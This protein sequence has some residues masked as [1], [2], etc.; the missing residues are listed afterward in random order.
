M[1]S[2]H[3]SGLEMS[4]FTRHG[5]GSWED[6]LVSRWT[7]SRANAVDDALPEYA[8][9]Q[10]RFCLHEG[11]LRESRVGQTLA[12][13]RH[14]ASGCGRKP[15]HGSALD[16]VGNF[17]DVFEPS[18]L[19]VLK[20]AFG[21][22]TDIAARNEHRPVPVV[23]DHDGNFFDAAVQMWAALPLWRKPV[24]SAVLRELL[25][26][27][28]S[29]GL[30]VILGMI[31]SSAQHCNAGK[32]DV[33]MHM[34]Q[35]VQPWHPSA[36]STSPQ[37]NEE[38]SSYFPSS[39]SSRGAA[40]R[41][42]LHEAALAFVDDWK[43]K[44]FVSTFLEPTKMYY[45]ACK[46]HGLEENVGVHGASVYLAV[47]MSTLG[48]WCP[49]LPFLLDA[50]ISAVSFLDALD[51]S[52]IRALWQPEHLG[53]PF[54]S[55]VECREPR[56][57]RLI[58]N[59]QSNFLF[60]GRQTWQIANNAVDPNAEPE[61]RQKLQPYLEQFAEYFSAEILVPKLT[62][63]LLSQDE[64]LQALEV[65]CD[66]MR[67]AKCDDCSAFGRVDEI[68]DVRHWLWNC[69]VFPAELRL[70]RAIAL[71]R[72]AGLLR[73]DLPLTDALDHGPDAIL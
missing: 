2:P 5:C 12:N 19:L 54:S 60:N 47:L 27:E 62:Q 41:A 32:V 46:E 17:Y 43:E 58:S 37:P 16:V 49:R 39:S 34:L 63:H 52:Q 65:M 13:L 36:S 73:R 10:R 15:F 68:G 6:Y 31:K 30:Q 24:M 64:G 22:R 29:A 35:R 1:S 7:S 20:K 66:E 11:L 44:A 28:D 8:A 72:H 70:G 18:L 9:A 59:H 51:A 21:L 26:L 50:P 38:P 40:A 4:E 33:W 53:K 14:R 71:L 48:V 23:A 25:T 69:E 67:N 56:L 57:D 61:R 45:A 3:I 55:I 42:R